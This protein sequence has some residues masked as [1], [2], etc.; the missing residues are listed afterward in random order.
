MTTAFLACKKDEKTVIKGLVLDIKT[1]MPIDSAVVSY[2]LDREDQH[3]EANTLSTNSA[4]KFTLSYDYNEFV[5]N[6]EIYKP[7]Y[8]NV[9]RITNGQIRENEENQIVY[10]LYPRDAVL[11]IVYENSK[12]QP[13]TV[14]LQSQT[15]SLKETYGIVPFAIPQPYPFV[16]NAYT[17]DSVQVTY[18]SEEMVHIYWDLKPYYWV[19]SASHIDSFYMQKGDTAVYKVSL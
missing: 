4:G 13:Y 7:G 10:K 12:P 1:R 6:F 9:Y 11:R 14:Y 2:S 17:K 3:L 18:P 5:S 16:I 15:A 19:N 8:L